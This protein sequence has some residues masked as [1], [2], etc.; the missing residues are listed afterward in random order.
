MSEIKRNKPQHQTQPVSFR[1]KKGEITYRLIREFKRVPLNDGN[2][3]N[4]IVFWVVQWNGQELKDGTFS[5]PPIVFEKRK[6]Y[7]RSD[8]KIITYKLLGWTAE[9]FVWLRNNWN[10]VCEAVQGV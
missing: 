3:H 7:I 10:E 6:I 4:Y 1:K 8:G 5:Q 9:D 2:R